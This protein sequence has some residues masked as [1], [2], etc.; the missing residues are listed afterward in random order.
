MFFGK[1]GGALYKIPWRDGVRM[2]L[3]AQ[4]PMVIPV[5]PA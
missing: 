4:A 1:H 3:Y 2:S 5:F